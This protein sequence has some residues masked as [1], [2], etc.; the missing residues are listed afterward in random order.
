MKAEKKSINQSV[1]MKEITK[2]VIVFL[3]IGAAAI[4]IS[5]IFNSMVNK[6]FSNQVALI[7]H[8]NEYRLASKRLTYDVQSFAASGKKEYNDDY[9]KELEVDKN[10]DSALKEMNRIGIHQNEKDIL[11]K[12]ADLSNNLVPLEVEAISLASEG[13]NDAAIEAVFSDDYG[14]T[15]A[16]I[17]QLS[18]E[19]IKH[20]ETRTSASVRF[21]QILSFICQGIVIVCFLFIVYQVMKLI[22]FS[23]RELLQPILLVE[24]QMNLIAEGN[25]SAEFEL[26]ENE[27]EVGRMIGSIHQ[28]K[29]T[30]KSVISDIETVLRAVSNRDLTQATKAEYVGELSNIEISVK[31][32]LS[33]L[34][35]IIYHIIETAKQVSDGAEQISEGSQTLAEGATEQASAVEELQATIED[36][37]IEV[38]KNAKNAED[39][40][41][42]AKTVGEEIEKSN[43]EMSTVINSML[44]IS[45]CSNEIGNIISTIEEIASQ[46][47]LLSLNASIEAARAGE[48]GR[49]F[50]VVADE[51]GKLAKESAEAARVSSE[52]IHASIQAV[53]KGKFVINETADKLNAAA[54]KT[55][56]L[57]NSIE[58][59]SDVSVRQTASLGQVN[60]GVEQI[61][62]IIQ[63]NAAM[64]EESASASEELT[65]EAKVL[66]SMVEEFQLSL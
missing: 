15:V 53:E 55:K 57:L 34:N 56:G 36:V 45:R 5:F 59:I 6:Q 28:M 41:K 61:S 37:L 27:S 46:T 66:H 52:L 42:L 19:L 54:S 58:E 10:R 4:V 3:I 2:K 38:E 33:S 11:G 31:D 17:N 39:A 65:A 47:N 35:E 63:E 51:V 48:A 14:N 20:I 24:K 32:I 8:T 64:S 40:N 22:K 30:L 60:L 25:F 1:I 18:D 23:V 44:E 26:E 21:F 62:S 50:A 16:Q 29:A 12:I 43:E 49:G 7:Q 13:K 9:H